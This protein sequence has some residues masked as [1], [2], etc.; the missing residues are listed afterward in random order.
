MGPGGLPG[1]QNRSLPAHAGRLGSTPRRFRQPPL[2]NLRPASY[3]LASKTRRN[4]F[5]SRR[6]SETLWPKP[7][8]S[9]SEIHDDADHSLCVAQILEHHVRARRAQFL[10]TMTARCDRDRARA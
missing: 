2:A 8:E 10:R 9:P 6:D 7:S 4:N 5:S 3:G 1:L